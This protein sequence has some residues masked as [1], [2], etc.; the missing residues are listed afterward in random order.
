MK[1]F[2]IKQGEE[3]ISVVKYGN[4]G[5]VLVTENNASVFVKS[6]SGFSYDV[7]D[8]E[9]EAN[10]LINSD[11]EK[12]VWYIMGSVDKDSDYEVDTEVIVT[13]K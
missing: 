4:D 8:N 5:K 10:V 11:A 7:T 2:T 9:E 3:T 13:Y 12:I 6:I 1:L